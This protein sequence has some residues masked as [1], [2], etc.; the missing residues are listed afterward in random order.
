M[1]NAEI[2]REFQV[3]ADTVTNWKKRGCPLESINKTA[4]WLEKNGKTK[5]I[6]EWKIRQAKVIFNPNNSLPI[7]A[8]E[9]TVK[10]PN[11]ITDSSMRGMLERIQAAELSA[12]QEVLNASPG[13]QR[14]AVLTMYSTAVK[15]RIACEK[16]IVDLIVNMEELLTP[17]VS[18]DRIND[19]LSPIAKM[20]N[21]LASNLSHKCNPDNPEIAFEALQTWAEKCKDKVRDALK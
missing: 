7:I 11:L 21:E 19:A 13:G 16:E 5:I 20:L 14:A 1:T 8:K 15:L 4:E 2:S 3:T 17:Q 12:Y 9:P 6:T 10:L 18:K